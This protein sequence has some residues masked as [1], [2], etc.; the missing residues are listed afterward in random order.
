M[1]GYLIIID[2]NT[3]NILKITDIFNNFKKKKR[4]KI[5]P[6]G[7]VVGLNKIFLSTTNGRLLI[8]D[9]VSGKTI[10][11]LKIDSEKISRPFVS[12]KNLFVIK[13]NSIIKL[14]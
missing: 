9:L 3:G 2:K 7:F 4:E 14:D 5:K 6:M 8:I 11:T 13:D 12:N 1:E 10:T